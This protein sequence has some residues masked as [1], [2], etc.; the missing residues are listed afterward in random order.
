MSVKASTVQEGGTVSLLQCY[1]SLQARRNLRPNDCIYTGSEQET[2]GPIDK[3]RH[4]DLH[5]AEQIRT[6]HWL[7]VKNVPRGVE[8]YLEN[9][10]IEMLKLMELLLEIPQ[11]MQAHL[12]I[13]TPNVTQ[14]LVSHH[15]HIVFGHSLP[16]ALTL[17]ESVLYDQVI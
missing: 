15:K 9:L 12:H 6:L 10:I 3:S 16:S 17:S 7:G 14:N 13:A 5:G 4:H 2:A 11:V 1:H 8:Q